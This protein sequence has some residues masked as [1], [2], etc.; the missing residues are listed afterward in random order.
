MFTGI[1][2]GSVEKYTDR[3]LKAILKL[4]HQF[5]TWPNKTERKEIS[6]R[7]AHY[8]GMPDCIGVVDGTP[9]NLAQKPHIDGEVYFSRKSRYC[10]NLQ[11]V[12]DDRRNIRFFQA[13]WPGSVFD[14]TVFDNSDICQNPDS[15]ISAGQYIIADSGY[16]AKWFICTPYKHPAAAIPENQLFNELFSSA[17]CVIEH[18]NGVLK[19]RFCS[20]KGVRIQ[21]KKVCD[22]EKVNKWIAVC[23]IL[24]N[25]LNQLNDMW[26][27]VDEENEVSDEDVN[28]MRVNSTALDLRLKV[29]TTLLE[30]YFRNRCS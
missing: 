27:D 12:C 11:L 15:F 6:R 14:S 19:G 21:V 3:V 25:I 4:Q 24:H 17:R 26:D 1:S 13:G 7:F 23:C 9:V 2:H 20:L 16:G 22:F 5:I 29:Q 28:N 30:W 10:I 8:H 18:V